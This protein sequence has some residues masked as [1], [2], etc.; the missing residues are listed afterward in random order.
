VARPHC[1]RTDAWA[2]A[3][4]CAC[5][6]CHRRRCWRRAQGDGIGDGATD[7]SMGEEPI[8]QMLLKKY[9]MYARN[10]VRPQLTEI[11]T[12]KASGILQ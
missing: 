8:P 9:I 10:H 7:V 12:E 6:R 2:A 3:A 11:D 4:L 1:T 5:P